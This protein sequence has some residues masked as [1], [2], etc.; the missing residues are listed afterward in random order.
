MGTA[1]ILAQVN[2]EI[3]RLQRIKDMLE[4]DA[5]SP[6]YNP[7]RS[8]LTRPPKR[9][10]SEEAKQRIREAQRKRWSAERG[11]SAV[12]AETAPEPSSPAP[13]AVEAPAAEPAPEEEVAKP[14]KSALKHPPKHKK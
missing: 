10:M 8:A 5:P 6:T 11:E 12:V 13:A 7:Q 2:R 4:E 3:D 14:V 1:S 9:Q